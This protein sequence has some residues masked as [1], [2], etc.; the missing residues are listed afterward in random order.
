MTGLNS[1][2]FFS[3][4]GYFTDVKFHSLR[5]LLIGGGK[6]V[7]FKQFPRVLALLEMQTALSRN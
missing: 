7:G 1:K 5:Y 4:I 3:K 6:I 2:F